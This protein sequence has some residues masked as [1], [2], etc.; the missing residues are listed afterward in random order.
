MPI[1]IVRRGWVVA[2]N[3]CNCCKSRDLQLVYK[4]TWARC[5]YCIYNGLVRVHIKRIKMSLCVYHYNCHHTQKMPSDMPLCFVLN[6]HPHLSCNNHIN[7]NNGV[8]LHNIVAVN[9]FNSFY[10]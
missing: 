10:L 4:K 1:Y 2:L 8:E 6:N 7:N 5:V 9:A 3:K